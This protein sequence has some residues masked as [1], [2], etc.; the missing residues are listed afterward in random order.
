[1]ADIP[2][3]LKPGIGGV[4]FAKGGT[5][6]KIGFSNEIALR[7]R[8]LQTGC[9]FIIQF[10]GAIIGADIAV[11]ADLHAHFDADRA[12]GEWFEYSPRLAEF[13]RLVRAN[14]KQILANPNFYAT[15]RQ[16]WLL[17]SI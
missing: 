13:I 8:E 16:S 9:P 5:R 14:Q 17:L 1:M 15:N 2:A 7:M 10:V 6:L 11:E 12:H 3:W 4:Y